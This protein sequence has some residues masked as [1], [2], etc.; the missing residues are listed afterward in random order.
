M[1]ATSIRILIYDNSADFF[2]I[3][4]LGSSRFSLMLAPKGEAVSATQIKTGRRLPLCAKKR[5]KNYKKWKKVSMTLKRL[6]I[7]ASFCGSLGAKR[8]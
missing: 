3:R 1:I 8:H 5:N 7:V 6:H 2:P 4:F